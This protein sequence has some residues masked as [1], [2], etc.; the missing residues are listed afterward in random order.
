MRI[1]VV[2]HVAFEGPGGVRDWALARGHALSETDLSAGE[3]LPGLDAF[4][5]LVLMG[6]PMS[7]NEEDRY[8]WLR[9]E[10][11]LL[12][13]ALAADKKLLGICLGAQMIASA[14]GAPIAPVP[15]KEIG[16]FPVRALPGA[17]GH[18]FL[19]A[20]PAE[21]T[22]FHWHGEGFGLPAGAQ[23]L[24][25]SEAWPR[26]A[27]ALGRQ[28]LALQCHPEVTLASMQAM[29]DGGR[30]E[31]EPGRPFI[32][33]EAEILAQAAERVKA[34]APLLGGLLD[35]WSA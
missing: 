2:K 11:A 26:Q 5:A 13:A 18:P 8:A 31:L 22:V 7:V 10:K 29:I 30:E 33:A 4:D 24:W 15:E 16:W 6:G 28:A 35:A 25:G 19:R 9:P 23:A 12:R 21:Q 27:F 3:P 20:W 34:L 32:Q 14:L 17:A 1:H